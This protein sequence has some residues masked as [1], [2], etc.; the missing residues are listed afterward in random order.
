MCLH[1]LLQIE[2][3]VVHEAVPWGFYEVHW[4]FN[5]PGEG[6]AL[7]AVPLES[8]ELAFL[9]VSPLCVYVFLFLFVLVCVV[10]IFF[11]CVLSCVRSLKESFA[12]V[13]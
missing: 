7:L 9:I 4:G 10:G 5:I 2:R 1:S 3:V 12:N 11:L 13:K 6:V 8:W